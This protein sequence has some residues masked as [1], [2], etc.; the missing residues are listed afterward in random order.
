MLTVLAQVADAMVHLHERNICHGDLK[1]Q[2]V[3]LK[4]CPDRPPLHVA[5]KIT[6]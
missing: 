5:A 6:E 1:P 2:N 4:A 3:L